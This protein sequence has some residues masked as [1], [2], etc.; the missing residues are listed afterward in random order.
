VLTIP[1]KK[2]ICE[3]VTFILYLQ[4][5]LKNNRD[6]GMKVYVVTECGQ[7][8]KDMF[9]IQLG[10]YSTLEK[11][12]VRMLTCYIKAKEHIETSADYRF[13]DKGSC[14]VDPMETTILFYNSKDE[15]CKHFAIIDERIIDEDADEF[16]FAESN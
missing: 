11:A 15:F 2:F 9:S 14:E 16:L 10:V 12:Q 3:S 6:M 13:L 1:N 7:D 8:G 5:N 4:Y